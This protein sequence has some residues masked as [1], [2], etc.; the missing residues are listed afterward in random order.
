IE[1]VVLNEND[2]PLAGANIMLTS[3]EMGASTNQNGRFTISQ[4]PSGTYK[5]SVSFI[6]YE[7]KTQTVGLSSGEVKEIRFELEET[8]IR[9]EPVVVTGSPVAVNPLKSPQDID[10]ISG[11]EKIRSQSASMGETIESIPG[12]S[13]MSA[14][15]VAG[16]PVI[17]GLTGERI[18][19]MLD[20]INQE[21]QQ[22]GE[23][24]APNIDPFNAERVE[25]IKGAASLM[26]GSDAIG[27]AVNL[28]PPNFQFYSADGPRYSGNATA[29]YRSNNSEFMSGARINSSINKF[30]LN[31]SIV[32][33]TAA[34]FHT[35]D[36]KSFAETNNPGDPKFTGRIDHTD[37]EQLNGSIGAGF[38]SGLG[39]F[40]LR[41]DHYLNKNNFLLP[42]GGPIGLTLK[43][44]TVIAKGSNPL[45]NSIIRTKLS[46]QR[47]QRQATKP[48]LSRQSLPDSSHVDLVSR[49]YTGRVEYEH[50]AFSGFS[51]TAGAEVKYHDHENV[52]MVPLQPTGYYINSALFAFEEW[53]ID[54]FTV[55]FGMRY[56]YRTQKFL[57]TETNPLLPEDDRRKFSSLS[58][59]VGASYQVL[60]NTT[61]AVNFGRGF[62]TPSA[63]NLYVFGYHGGV[64]AYQIGE[65]DLGNEISYDISGSLRFQDNRNQAAIT[66]YQN[67]INNYIFLYNAPDH[68]LAPPDNPFVFSH[69]QADAVL[70]GF[71][72][73]L[74]SNLTNFFRVSADYSQIATEFTQGPHE[75]A[76]LPLIPADHFNAEVRFLLPDLAIMNSPYFA[77]TFSYHDAKAA[78]GIYEP[79]GQFDPGIGPDIPFG[80]A[81]T[82]AH[83]LLGILAGF[84]T[85][86]S[87][88]PVII[89]LE[90]T[91]LLDQDY[92]NF[93]DT[94]KGYTLGPG[95]SVNMTL[96][97]QL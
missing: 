60:D 13:N 12:V 24:H 74:E 2:E 11:R 20:G 82:D 33:R 58:G 86:I 15:S 41:Y 43:N 79:F 65:P 61:A 40:S 68:P 81:S 45:Q 53:Q 80:V 83:S 67:R 16:K 28:I 8:L 95:R 54:R 36:V 17:R 35:P 19:V 73:S 94:Y 78:A 69:D 87:E 89:D 23:R 88:V 9:S 91:N 39:M 59:A 64:F 63:Y 71:V 56:D 7:S 27:G 92:R 1:G 52:G 26:Y 97:I 32:R 75:G 90:I 93:L 31:A 48:G 38:L 25:V 76:G 96:N 70:T 62:R 44:Q 66:L 5:V 85:A 34:D 84:E 72:M 77:I 47:N 22:Y 14:G 6:G 4:I 29:A 46:Y 50:E 42:T 3:L 30:A 51:G 18:R 37:F 21:Y 55:N 10:Y 57:G 49:I